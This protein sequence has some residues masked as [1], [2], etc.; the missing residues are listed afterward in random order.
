MQSKLLYPNKLSHIKNVFE[1]DN[2]TLFSIRLIASTPKYPSAPKSSPVSKVSP[3]S[4]NSDSKRIQPQLETPSQW[5][6]Y[7]R[8]LVTRYAQPTLKVHN[9]FYEDPLLYSWLSHNLPKEVSLNIFNHI[10]NN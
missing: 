7:A 2:L 4:N 3:R 8:S 10:A 1:N 9:E 6:H 5:S